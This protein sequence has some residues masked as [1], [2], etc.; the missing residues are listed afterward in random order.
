MGGLLKFFESDELAMSATRSRVWVSAPHTGGIKIPE[1]TKHAVE[2]RLQAHFAKLG[3]AKRYRL[4]VRFRGA[5]CYVDAYSLEPDMVIIERWVSQ[6][7]DVEEAK[8]QF[9][10]MPTKLGRLRHFALDRWSY[11]FYTYSNERYE[12]TSLNGEWTG[13][14]EQGLEIGCGYLGNGTQ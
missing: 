2:A 13:L 10:P 12:A 6:G 14:P 5:L 8:A 9:L 4:D 7:M 1:K 3:L 11:A